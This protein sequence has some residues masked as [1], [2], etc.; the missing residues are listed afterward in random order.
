MVNNRNKNRQVNFE[1]IMLNF[2]LLLTKRANKA[3]TQ[4]S[5][6][7]LLD[8]RQ[9]L[10]KSGDVSDCVAMTSKCESVLFPLKPCLA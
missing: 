2:C 8:D 6:H 4:S 10:A 3:R 9:A 7:S 1:N 5:Q